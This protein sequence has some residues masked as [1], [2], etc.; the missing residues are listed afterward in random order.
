MAHCRSTVVYV[1]LTGYL[2]PVYKSLIGNMRGNEYHAAVPIEIVLWEVIAKL[3]W[4]EK[5]TKNVI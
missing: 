4:I 3:V 1:W 2:T 5:Q